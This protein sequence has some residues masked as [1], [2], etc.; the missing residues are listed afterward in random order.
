VGAAGDRGISIP[1][2]SA[3]DSPT[4]KGAEDDLQAIY[5]SD[6]AGGKPQH[7]FFLEA[8]SRHHGHDLW[9]AFGQRP[10]LVHHER[11][12]LLHPLQ[13]PFVRRKAGP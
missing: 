6:D 3:F 2:V 1:D 5:R 12:D 8:G 11:I 10:G 7:V 9:F 13:R 4:G